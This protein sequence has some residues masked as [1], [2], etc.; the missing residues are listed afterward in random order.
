MCCNLINVC[1]WD[2]NGQLNIASL[3]FHRILRLIPLLAATILFLV[4][5]YRFSGDGP[6]W[7]TTTSY[8]TNCETN[9]W[10]TLL[11]IQNY[12]NT[13]LNE[14]H[15]MVC[16]GIYEDEKF[17]HERN[18]KFLFVFQCIPQAWYLAADFQLFLIAPFFVYALRRYEWKM[19]PITLLL[20]L[21][22][23]LVLIFSWPL[24]SSNP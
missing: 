1:L 3:Y 9:W 20:L 8:R 16:V 14:R 21:A 24:G 18:Y 10:S 11:H 4:S 13:K 6:L 17:H 22:S 15:D 12:W 5:I 19:I 2:R 23:I 7:Y